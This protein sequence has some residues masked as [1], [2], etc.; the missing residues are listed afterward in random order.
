MTY[1]QHINIIKL[2]Q[3]D[4][5]DDNKWV[6]IISFMKQIP[7][8]EVGKYSVKKY[9]ELR[10]ECTNELNSLCCEAKEIGSFEFD[11]TEYF[12]DPIMFSL[13]TNQYADYIAIVDRY[14]DSLDLN[15]HILSLLIYT[16]GN[17]EYFTSRYEQNIFKVGRMPTEIIHGI[18]GFFFLLLKSL[19]QVSQSSLTLQELTQT[20]IQENISME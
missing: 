1:D 13:N 12:V 11:G 18:C 15:K 17:E 6:S 7:I 16:K 3:S 2:L 8:E 20:Q 9:Y 4:K 10:N 19:Q 5:P 14:K